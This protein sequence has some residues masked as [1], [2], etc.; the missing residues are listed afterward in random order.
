MKLAGFV[1]A[2]AIALGAA[3]P[4]AATDTAPRTFHAEY[5]QFGSVKP[6]VVLVHGA[7]ADASSFA[8]VTAELQKDGYKVLNAPN[9]V[10]GLE[11]DAANVAAF[12]NQHT[13]GPVVLVGHSYGGS[14]ITQAATQT[15]SVKALVYVDAYAPDTGDSVISLTGAQPG[16]ALA[17]PD[18]S[19]VFDFVQYPQPTGGQDVDTYIKTSLFQQIFAAALP[20]RQT[21]ILAANQTPTPLSALE[22]PLKTEPAWKTIKSYFFIGTRDKVIPPAEQFAMAYRANGVVTTGEADHLSMLE[23]PREVTSVIEEAAE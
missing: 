6:T 4:A 7:W 12:I 3:F 5:R 21:D 18:P 22:A 23:T 19:T 14:V 9:P 8:P 13:T 16:S 17:T 15:P 2:T 11:T 10:R 20:T 1:A